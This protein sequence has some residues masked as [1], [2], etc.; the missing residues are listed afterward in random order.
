MTPKMLLESLALVYIS[1]LVT[2]ER[3]IQA[4]CENIM[5]ML[6]KFVRKGI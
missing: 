2:S 1:V 4:R 6:V 5:K 3:R